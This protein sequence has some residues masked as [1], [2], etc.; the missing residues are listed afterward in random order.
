MDVAPAVELSGDRQDRVAKRA[1]RDRSPLGVGIPARGI[2]VRESEHREARG[3]SDEDRRNWRG[4]RWRKHTGAGVGAFTIDKQHRLPAAGS[5]DVLRLL[6]EEAESA[7]DNGDLAR[8]DARRRRDRWI[9]WAAP[10]DEDG[11]AADRLRLLERGLGSR[12]RP[13]GAV[14]CRQLQ[15]ERTEVLVR[16]DRELVVQRELGLVAVPLGRQNDSGLRAQLGVD[17]W[18]VAVAEEDRSGRIR[19]IE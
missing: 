3:M 6:F 9:A 13:D 11:G 14:D 16:G 1:D 5:D 8:A 7:L 12:G 4:E 10:A 18:I 2:V 17:R 15:T 19:H